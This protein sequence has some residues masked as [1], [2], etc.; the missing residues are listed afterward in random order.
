MQFPRFPKCSCQWH[1][2]PSVGADIPR[3]ALNDPLS[4][5]PAPV[6]FTAE[7]AILADR[8]RKHDI[9][10]KAYPAFQAAAFL[11][12]KSAEQHSDRRR[13]FQTLKESAESQG[14]AIPKSIIELFTT[15]S[16]IDR[17]HHNCVWP[18]LPAQLVRL[19]ADPAL[20]VLLFLVEGQ[21][22]DFWHLLLAPDGTHT[23]IYSDTAIGRPRNRPPNISNDLAKCRVF[24]CM[25]SVN[26]LLCSYFNESA[27]H[28][29]QYVERLTQYFSQGSN[30]PTA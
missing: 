24:Q 6:E 16:S 17:L 3:E 28:D 9:D 14:F 18:M 23:V 21:G 4:F 8:Y 30:E 29:E 11:Q 25:V 7:M 15:D 27:R 12:P 26:D 5:L 20:V 22:S 10:W 1:R 2:D 13:H 19:P